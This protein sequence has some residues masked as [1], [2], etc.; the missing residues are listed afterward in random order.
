M[1]VSSTLL[2]QHIVDFEGRYSPGYHVWWPSR[3]FRHEVLEN[4]ANLLKS[5]RLL[6]RN[7]AQAVMAR[8]IAPIE[9]IRSNDAAH[10][11]ARLYF[12]PR[13]PTQ[14]LIEGIRKEH[15]IRHGRQAP[16]LC[17]F[18]FQRRA[19]L[20]RTDVVF[21][22]GNMQAGSAQVL[23][24]DEGFQTLLFDRIYH[25][26]SY[27]TTADADIKVWR[28]AEV[29]ATSPLVLDDCLEAVVCRSHAERVTLLHLLGASAPK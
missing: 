9:I 16:T 1:G 17:M 22:N 3:L 19:L 7:D 15:E 25:E 20:C 8:D 12:R 28:C 5:G 2:E 27:N 11:Y 4:A 18:V 14:Y 6:S 21:S 23:D 24:G 10:G 26:G 29:L 13:T